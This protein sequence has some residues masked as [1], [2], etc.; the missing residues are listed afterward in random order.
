MML[1]RLM[2][3]SKCPEGILIDFRSYSTSV[4]MNVS[5]VLSHKVRTHTCKPHIRDNLQSDHLLMK[6]AL[7]ELQQ[8]QQQH[9]HVT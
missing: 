2:T 3:L 8:Q 6:K 4:I 1:S 7:N 9:S 5:H